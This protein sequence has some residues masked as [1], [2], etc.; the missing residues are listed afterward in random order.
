MNH[1]VARLIGKWVT[2]PNDVEAL[3]EY[4]TVTLE[5]KDD[6]SLIYSIHSED[7]IQKVK[8]T[9]KAEQGV[10]ITD[11][12]SHPQRDRT[13]FTFTADGKLVLKYAGQESQY[14]RADSKSTR[15]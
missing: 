3:E 14:I 5:F 1:D 10:L 12:P 2:D 13:P 4:G 6:G 7:K 15:E 8:L 11:Q 9:Y